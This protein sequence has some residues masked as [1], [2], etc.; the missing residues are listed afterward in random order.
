MPSAPR[1][2]VWRGIRKDQSQDYPSDTEMVWWA[3]SS[4]TTSLSHL[5]YI[6]IIHLQQKTPL[7]VLLEPPFKDICSF[8]ET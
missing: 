7:H 1:Q 4:C 5:I 2:I 3:F 6:I 8:L